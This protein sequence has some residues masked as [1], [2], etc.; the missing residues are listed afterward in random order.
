MILQ[1][2]IERLGGDGL[3]FGGLPGSGRWVSVTKYAL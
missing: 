3:D 2:L 1:A